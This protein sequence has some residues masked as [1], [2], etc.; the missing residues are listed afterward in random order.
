MVIHLTVNHQVGPS[1]VLRWE[2]PLVHRLTVSQGAVVCLTTI[3]F[4]KLTSSLHVTYLPL[5]NSKM[6]CFSFFG[7]LLFNGG[8]M[9]FTVYFHHVVSFHHRCTYTEECIH[10]ST[11]KTPSTG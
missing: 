8:L 5:S 7:F 2:Q 4:K 6:H 3:Y 9:G 11:W 1:D 10:I